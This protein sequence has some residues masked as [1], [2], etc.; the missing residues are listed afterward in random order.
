MELTWY[1]IIFYLVAPLSIY[2]NMWIKLQWLCNRFTVVT[3]YY[4]CT[5]TAI[6]FSI[7]GGE[8]NVALDLIVNHVHQQLQS[9]SMD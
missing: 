6:E 3:F 7:S 9:V 5:I 1:G 2:I 8:N 4:L